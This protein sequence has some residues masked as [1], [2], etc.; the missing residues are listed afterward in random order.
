M[1]SYNYTFPKE[2]YHYGV[3]GMKWGVRRTKDELKYDRGSIESSL[4]RFLKTSIIVNEIT[5]KEVSKHA[6]DQAVNRKISSK[7]M[8]DAIKFPLH[9]KE[10]KID[11]F[12]RTSQRFIG[13]SATVNINPDTGIITTVWST[14]TAMKQKYLKE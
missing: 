6:L 13:K 8:I 7:E 12:G 2:L 1:C 14:G 9:I 3:K 4:N 5:V 10:R 11:Q